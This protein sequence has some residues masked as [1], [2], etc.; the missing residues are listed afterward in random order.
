M[1][2]GTPWQLGWK[3]GGLGGWLA[4]WGSGRLKGCEAE[5]LG[6]WKAGG[7]GGWGSI[8]LGG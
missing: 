6:F 7:L 3:A 8:R 1:G 4:D 2:C 5:R